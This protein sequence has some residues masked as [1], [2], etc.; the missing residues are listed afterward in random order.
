MSLGAVSNANATDANALNFTNVGGTVTLASLTGAGKTTFGSAAAVTG[1]ISAGLVN[2]T[3]ALSSAISGGTVNAASLA[4]NIS[5]SATTTI[6]GL[7][8]GTIAGTGTLSAGSLTSSSVTGGTNAI[9]GAATVTT[10]NGGTTTVGGIATVTTL[11]TGT[12]N[13]NG[14]I[15]SI[16]T[17]NGGTVALG[18]LTALSVSDGTFAGVISGSTGSLTKASVGTLILTGANTYAGGTTISGGTL[19]LGN[20]GTSGSIAAGDVTNSGTFAISR[21]DDLTFASKITGA[22]AFTKLG[23][24]NL[25]LT[26]A[27]DFTGATLISAGT[28][29]SAAGALASTSGITVN[30]AIFAAADYNLAATLALDTTATA[31]ISAADLSVTGAIANAGTTAD[32]LNFSAST[33]K[34]ILTSLAGVGK[35]RFGAAA[36]ITGG[37]AE[38]TVTVVGVLGANITGGTVNA[39]SLAGDVSGG[40]V[41]VTGALTGNVLAGAGTVSAGSMTGSVASSVTV[42][43]LLTGAITLGTN[44]LGSLSSTSVTGGTNTITGAA[45]VTTVNGG[46]TTV[47]GVATIATLT[48]GTVNLRGASATIG[49]L[50]D[51]TVNL[52]TSTLSTA[53]TVNDGTFAGL[54][55]GANGS[56]IKASSGTLTLSGANTY[57]GGTS[58]NLGTLTIGTIGSLGTGAVAVGS[59]ATLNLAGF[60]VTN[61]ITVATGGTIENGPTAA[62]PAVV[63]ALSGTNSID[64]VLTGTT[65]LA[66][67]GSGELTLSTPNFFTGAVTANTAGAVIKAAFLSDTSSSLGASSL[68]DPTKLVLGSGATLEFTGL[69]ATTTT[70]SF[71]IDGSAGIAAGA[72][73]ATLTFTSASKIALIGS[74]PALKL[75][76]NNS[77]TNFFRAS[78]T[79]DDIDAG[80]GIKNLAIDGSGTWVIGGN[81]NR[82]KQDIRIDAGAGSTI[83]LENGA[84]PSGATLAVANNATVRWEAGNTTPV[85]LEVVAGTTAKL[86]LGANNVVFTTAPTVTGTGSTT[87]QKQGSGSLKIASTVIAPTVDLDVSAGLLSVNG[88]V[89]NVSL[90]SGATLGGGGTVGNVIAGAGSHVS[91]G[92]SPGILSTGNFGFVAGSFYDWQ[93]QDAKETT[94][95]PGYDKLAISGNFD[96]R[97]ADPANKITISVMSLMNANDQGNPLNFDPPGGRASIR[98]FTFAT[99]TGQ[100][101]TVLLNSGVNIS[102]VFQFDVNQFRY[103]DGSL[104]NVSLWSINWDG[105]NLV[106]L[107]AVPEPSTYGFGLGA[108]ALAAAAIRRRRKN[109]PKA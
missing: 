36:D 38:G 1:G 54:L 81:A 46:T 19:Q 8:N 39:G 29:T 91:P 93:V 60:G 40:S 88:T 107:T 85:N 34:I 31:S 9:T 51:G 32:A 18:S 43:G 2:V 22:G 86:D 56:L 82:F 73:A 27:N 105:G 52:G 30:A 79:Q 23:T 55:A 101:S 42:S 68:T 96:L 41:T 65:G 15:S 49:T 102:D 99:L 84:L 72:N 48:S 59:G 90:A 21:S 6:T 66:K 100:N 61:A 44:A 78:L 89:G 97:Q 57:G 75:S 76:A 10:V 95:N 11:T 13:L 14:A 26:A 106:T 80:N 71:T 108:L 4:G 62:S 25:T 77:G 5:G 37:V 103:S 69:T 87:L 104:S 17:L 16:G 20:G 28:L 47:G 53:L 33:G 67:S 50:T 109:Q 12:L 92:N 63:A 70:R 35:T 94:V 24:G 98:V 74:N 3:G 58:V 64:T 7:T 83:G 45:T